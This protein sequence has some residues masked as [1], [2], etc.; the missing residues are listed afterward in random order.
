MSPPWWANPSSSSVPSIPSFTPIRRR[1]PYTLLRLAPI[2]CAAA[3]TGAPVLSCSRSCRCLGVSGMS[4]LPARLAFQRRQ[5]VPPVHAGHH[6]VEE[7]GI[8]VHTT[9]RRRPDELECL[10]AACRGDD[11]VARGLQVDLHQG[12]DVGL[13]VDDENHRHAVRLCLDDQATRASHSDGRSSSS[14]VGRCSGLRH[15]ASSAARPASRS[16]PRQKRSPTSY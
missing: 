2:C 13:V 5:H 8:E 7:H 12:P 14:R 4:E 15:A 6:D 11:D 9:R 1:L 16:T 3:V 10:F